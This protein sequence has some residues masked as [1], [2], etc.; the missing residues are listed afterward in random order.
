VQHGHDPVCP[1]LQADKA[2]AT[3]NK[4]DKAPKRNAGS[5]TS[6]LGVITPDTKRQHI[7]KPGNAVPSTD[8]LFGTL[9]YKGTDMMPT[10]NEANPT[11][12]LCAGRHCMGCNCPGAHPA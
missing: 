12:H 9:I 5:D 6:G 1:L 4:L 10:V 8:N 3:K 2:K 7:G 11:L